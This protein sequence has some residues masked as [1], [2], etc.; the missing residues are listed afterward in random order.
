MFKKV[1]RDLD[2]AKAPGSDCI[3]VVILRNCER[4]LFYIL[5]EL[6]NKCLKESVFHVVGRSYRWSQYLRMLG[7]G[8]LVSK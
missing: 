3:L 4:E 1:I 8:L 2:L 6:L 5:A 7:K